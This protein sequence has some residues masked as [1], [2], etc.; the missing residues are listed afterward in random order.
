MIIVILI[1]RFY[2]RMLS[3]LDRSIESALKSSLLPI[4]DVSKMTFEQ[5]YRVRI[6]VDL[7]ATFIYLMHVSHAPTLFLMFFSTKDEVN[8]M[9]S[10]WLTKMPQ[11]RHPAVKELQLFLK[12][13]QNNEA[14]KT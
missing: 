11:D 2:K 4:A 13:L 10:R 14:E 9:I 5:D 8:A 7:L 6:V 1:N 3:D 12:E